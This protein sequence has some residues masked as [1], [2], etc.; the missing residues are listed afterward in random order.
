MGLTEK[1]IAN[2]ELDAQCWQMGE[3]LMKAVQQA[4]HDISLKPK[5]K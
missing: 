4:I 1:K 3:Y 2:K 5:K